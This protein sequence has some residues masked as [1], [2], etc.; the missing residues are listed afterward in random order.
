M[1]TP[2]TLT[3][4]LKREYFDQV[5]S[6]TK[7]D[8][9][10]LVTP[11]WERRLQGV[12]FERVVLTL[13]Y[14]SKDDSARRLEFSWDGVRRTTLQHPL[15]GAEPVEVFAISLRRPLPPIPRSL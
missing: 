7:L 12:E 4:A 3:L 9:F 6:G 13:G 10:R 2:K 11:F 14:P 1:S 8:E 5:A 15:F